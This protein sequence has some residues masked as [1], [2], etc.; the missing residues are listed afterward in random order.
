MLVQYVI[1][2]SALSD[3]YLQNDLT[4][5]LLRT[6]CLINFYRKTGLSDELVP[7]DWLPN[8]WLTA[9][10][11]TSGISRFL[12]KFQILKEQHRFLLVRNVKSRHF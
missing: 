4:A 11:L 6:F 3:E 1:S 12:Y 2:A 7:T 9:E 8:D 10:W 5:S